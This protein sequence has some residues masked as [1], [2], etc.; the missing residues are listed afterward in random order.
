VRSEFRVASGAPVTFHLLPSDWKPSTP[1]NP[2]Y[3]AADGRCQEILMVE[4]T[5]HGVRAHGNILAQ[6]MPGSGIEVHVRCGRRIRETGTQGHVWARSIEMG[7]PRYC[8]DRINAD[9]RTRRRPVDLETSLVRLVSVAARQTVLAGTCWGCA[10]S[11]RRRTSMSFKIIGVKMSC[12]ASSIFP[13][14]HTMMFGRD[15]KESCTIDKRY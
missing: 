5:Q 13:P 14:G 3:S 6:A 1:C 10:P 15:M 12:M 8:R 7:N 11:A 2:Q 4:T 9:H